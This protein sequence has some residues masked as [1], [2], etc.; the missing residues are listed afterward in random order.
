MGKSILL[1]YNKSMGKFF[2]LFIL[3]LSLFVIISA[4]REFGSGLRGFI[5]VV[6]LLGMLG[7]VYSER[8]IVKLENQIEKINK[9]LA[10]KSGHKN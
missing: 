10:E 8:R 6:L 1:L 7:A 2:W 9:E 5:I 4:F 3:I